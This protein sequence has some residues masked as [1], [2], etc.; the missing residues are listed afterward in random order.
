MKPA[1]RDC[2]CRHQHPKSSRPPLRECPRSG[3]RREDLHSNP[4]EPRLSHR[5]A[6]RRTHVCAQLFYLL[7]KGCS[8][9]PSTETPGRLTHQLMTSSVPTGTTGRQEPDNNP[10]ST[11]RP[12]QAPAAILECW[13][14]GGHHHRVVSNV[15]VPP[16][17]HH[18]QR[19]VC[20]C[21][22]HLV[23]LS[24]CC[25]AC[26]SLFCPLHQRAQTKD[27]S[28][29]PNSPRPHTSRTPNTWSTAC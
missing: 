13:L 21:L 10:A 18:S 15:Q 28:K 7:G 29:K 14:S 25:A 5:R 24:S 20:V 16:I 8:P 27:L 19:A 23:S 17:S 3:P 6:L 11:I 9:P 4:P 2:T 22:V 1:T 26:L 12:T